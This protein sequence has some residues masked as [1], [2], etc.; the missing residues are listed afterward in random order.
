MI[1]FFK[2]LYLKYHNCDR[3]WSLYSTMTETK[4]GVTYLTEIE[5]RCIV[6][7]KKNISRFP[8]PLLRLETFRM[9]GGKYL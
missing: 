3:N 6:C 2:N 1:K 4:D 7:N 9:H 8:I 5:H